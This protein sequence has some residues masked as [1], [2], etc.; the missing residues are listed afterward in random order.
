M[1]VHSHAPAPHTARVGRADAVPI[2][3]LQHT[4]WD[5]AITTPDQVNCF[6]TSATSLRSPDHSL[7]A[8][9]PFRHP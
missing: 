8:P 5:P 7:V 3:P 4:D 2:L 6:G 1:A 9:S